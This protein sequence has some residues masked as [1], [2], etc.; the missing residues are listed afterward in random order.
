VPG[1]RQ[2]QWWQWWWWWWWQ[3]HAAGD[4]IGAADK[5]ACKPGFDEVCVLFCCLQVPHVG[6]LDVNRQLVR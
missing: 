2:Q 6:L 4:C 1:W 3:Q 5:G